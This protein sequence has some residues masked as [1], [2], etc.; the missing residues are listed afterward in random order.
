MLA[1]SHCHLDRLKLDSYDGKIDL[2]IAAAR[3]KTVEYILCPSVTTDSISSILE[4]V[5]LDSKLFAALGIHPTEKDASIP[6]YGEL[7]AMAHHGKIIAIG[8]TGLDFH[9]SHDAT[10]IQRQGEL[11]KLHIAVA[12]ELNKPLIVHSREAEKEIMEIL[13]R[14][15]ASRSGGVVHCFTGSEEMAMAALSLGFYLSFSGIITFPRAENL[16]SIAK[17]IPLDKMLIETDAPYLA[18]NPLRG[19]SNEPRY[20]PYIAEYMAN[21]LAIPYESFAQQMVEN[22]LRFCRIM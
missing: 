22:F 12:R 15:Q 3:A 11:F 1:D 20:L 19:K 17:L 16:R 21:L 2:A 4:I 14:E 9:H 18:P 8:E 7:L 10:E 5:N 6:S 13:V